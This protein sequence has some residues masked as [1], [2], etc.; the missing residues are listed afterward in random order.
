MPEHKKDVSTTYAGLRSLL[1]VVG[2]LLI[3]VGGILVLLGFIDFFSS[4][5]SMEPPRLFWMLFL[6]LPLVGVG[7]A[8]TKFGYLG[9]A[10]G[11]VAGEV[12]PVVK[13]TANYLAEGTE[14]AASSVARAVGR[15]VAEA[16]GQERTDGKT[17][18]HC[19]AAND[20]DADYCA[21]CGKGLTKSQPCPACGHLSYPDARFCDECGKE[22]G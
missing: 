19:R 7:G 10:A 14:E 21:S 9:V 8:L 13:D 1:R 6:G 18:P 20:A 4:F 5:G 2:P 3:A 22:L 15:G 11:Y 17:C 16:L 12:A